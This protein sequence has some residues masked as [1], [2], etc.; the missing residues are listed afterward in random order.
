MKASS[1]ISY[2]WSSV[3][4]ILIGLAS[5][6]LIFAI[7][8]V[9]YSWHFSSVARHTTGKI[10]AMRAGRNKETGSA[11]YAP[12]FRF[13][14]STGAVHTVTSSLYSSPP[15]FRVGDVVSVLYLSDNPQDAKID[16]LWQ[17]WG[18]PTMLSCI[19]SVGLII[20]IGVLCATKAKPRA[21]IPI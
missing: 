5:I 11:S 15:Q 2:D 19:G 6:F 13:H 16:T 3:G 18:L 1:T 7:G 9:I 17:I 8:A 4:N 10:V 12:T 14:D 21:I 20:G